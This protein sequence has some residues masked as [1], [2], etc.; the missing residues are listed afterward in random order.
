MLEYFLA[1]KSKETVLF[2]AQKIAEISTKP[3][4]LKKYESY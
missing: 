2:F 1:A 3:V 4:I